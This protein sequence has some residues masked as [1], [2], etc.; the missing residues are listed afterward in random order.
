[1][2]DGPHKALMRQA[3]YLVIDALVTEDG[4]TSSE[5]LIPIHFIK[6]ISH[7]S[8]GSNIIASVMPVI[9]KCGITLMDGNQMMVNHTFD[10][11]AKAL[12]AVWVK[13]FEKREGQEPSQIQ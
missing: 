10:D 8:Q 3:N 11:L 2:N 4:K 12:G 13:E 1:M 9:G 6:S 7:V 5:V